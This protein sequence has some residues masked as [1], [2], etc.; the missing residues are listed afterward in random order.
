[1]SNHF[2]AEKLKSP[3]D[4]TRL[5]LTDLDGVQAPAEPGKTVPT[6]NVSPFMIE[7]E[8]H[9]DGVYRP[10]TSQASSPAGPSLPAMRSS[11]F[12]SCRVHSAD[13]A[14]NGY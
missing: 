8:F 9:P 11:R 4:D 1:M 7:S 13:S 3:G 14:E 10:T 5:V 2:S 6:M 12:D